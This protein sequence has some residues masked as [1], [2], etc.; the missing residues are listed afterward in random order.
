MPIV[1]AHATVVLGPYPKGG[2][3][4]FTAP[5]TDNIFNFPTLNGV[6]ITLTYLPKTL[7]LAQGTVYNLT[8]GD[9]AV[10]YHVTT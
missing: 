10:T 9:V 3:I 7:T 5:Q 1:D 4:T 2:T 8:A 6:T